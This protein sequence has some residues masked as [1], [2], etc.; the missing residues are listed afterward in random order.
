[1]SVLLR[2]SEGG[3]RKSDYESIPDAVVDDVGIIG[4]PSI[5]DDHDNDDDPHMDETSIDDAERA[6]ELDHLVDTG[7]WEGVI[8]AAATYEDEQ[9]SEEVSGMSS[10]SLSVASD[11]RTGTLLS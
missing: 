5:S 10:G 3:V 6:A 7:N 11:S 1:M 9:K 4:Q 8:L 2:C